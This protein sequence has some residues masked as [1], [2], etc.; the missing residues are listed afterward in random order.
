MRMV[1]MVN[2]AE[3]FRERQSGRCHPARC[4]QFSRRWIFPTRDLYRREIEEL[5]RG[6]AH[7]ETEVTGR[8][9]EAAKRARTRAKYRS[10]ILPDQQGPSRVRENAWLPRAAAHA[11]FP[12][13]FGIG[14]MSY[15][16]MI[17][18]V[19]AIR[20]RASACLLAAHA[21]L[22]GWMFMVLGI[23]GFIPASDVAVA[24]V[25]RIITSGSAPRFCP[26]SHCATGIPP[27]L[28]TIVVVPTMLADIRAIEEQIERLEVHHLSNP[29][30]NLAFALLSDWNDAKTERTAEDDRLFDAAA[31]GIASLNERYG[32]MESGKRFFLLHRRRVWNGGE[33]KWIGWERK[34]GKL[35]ELNRCFAGRPTRLFARGQPSAH[36]A[37]GNQI[38]HHA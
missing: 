24:V 23:V 11:A 29:D 31:A 34:R 20:T 2:W 14:V 8:L 36:F 10:R 15:V 1:S 5:A 9:I 7:D 38:R 28:R 12:A 27:D 4:Q 37:G 17:G 18:I 13:Q 32:P 3:F 21:G 16:G 6:S 22:G 25:N 33:G 26:G 30:D 35:H 19:T